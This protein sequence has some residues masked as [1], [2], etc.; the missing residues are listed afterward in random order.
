MTTRNQ[1]ILPIL[2]YTHSKTDDLV[3]RTMIP[4]VSPEVNCLLIGTE[5]VT[6]GRVPS[7]FK[8][9]RSVKVLSSML[10]TLDLR[11]F[12]YYKR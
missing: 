12:V 2:W 4:P 6:E 8:L 10:A 5:S 1:T 7:I 11:L 9:I 3:V